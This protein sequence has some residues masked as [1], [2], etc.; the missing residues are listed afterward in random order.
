VDAISEFIQ[1]FIDQYPDNEFGII[2]RSFGGALTLS[3]QKNVKGISRLGLIAPSGI[4]RLKNEILEWSPKRISL[5]WDVKDPVINIANLQTLHRINHNLLVY[6]VGIIP[7]FG[8]EAILSISHENEGTHAPELVYPNLFN[9]FL[10]S[11]DYEH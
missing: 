10:A 9:D 3:I 6:S 7:K 4:D 5:L 1:Q 2:G 8:L 11:F